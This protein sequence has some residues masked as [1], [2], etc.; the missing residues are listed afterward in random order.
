MAEHPPI[1]NVP[2]IVTG[3][4]LLLAAIHL[5]RYLLAEDADRW[6]LLAMAFIPARYSGFA[7]E[8][9]GGDLASL[10]SFVT[11]MAVHGDLIHLGFNT[12]WLL[13]FGGALAKRLTAPAFLAF[14]LVC[15]I[16]GA[17]LFWAV[18]PGLMAPMVGASGALSGLMGAVLRLLMSAA[19]RDQVELLR[20]APSAVPLAPLSTAL[21]DRRLWLVTAVWIALNMLA[22]AGIGVPNDGIIAWEAHVGGFL[23][24][25]LGFGL[26]DFRNCEDD[27]HPAR[28]IE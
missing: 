3:I 23:C 9:P 22:I 8:L 2:R 15:G 12:A 24:G 20:I 26:F 7:A 10:T 14:A 18:N 13:A 27:K 17:L 1:F 5:G 19:D 25:V 21:R 11:H 4:V 6:L 16:A 28:L